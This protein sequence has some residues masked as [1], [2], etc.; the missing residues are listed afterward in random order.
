MRETLGGNRFYE[1]IFCKVQNEGNFAR[2]PILWNVKQAQNRADNCPVQIQIVNKTE[3]L[4]KVKEK[5]EHK[6]VKEI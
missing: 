2:E 5:R 3:E 1:K 4:R 6:Q